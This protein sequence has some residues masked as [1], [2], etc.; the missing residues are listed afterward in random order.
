MPRWIA[1]RVPARA[2]ALAVVATVVALAATLPA[3]RASGL[4][5]AA[6]RHCPAS[7][8]V[9]IEHKGGLCLYARSTPGSRLVLGNT[10]LPL[11]RPIILQG[12][13]WLEAGST[14]GAFLAAE[15]APTLGPVAEPV[16]GGLA[17]V[18]D[19]SL[20]SGG[21][22]AS[23]QRL[24][25]LGRTRVS[26]TIE[27]AG[28]ASAIGFS[29]ENLIG[30]RAVALALPLKI[31]LRSASGL[32][33]RSCYLGSDASPLELLFTD[34]M[35]SPPAPA[36]PIAGKVGMSTQSKS[37]V[38]TITENTLVENAFPLPAVEGCGAKSSWRTE[39]DAA[40]DTRLGLPSPAG[41]NAAILEDTFGA[42]AGT[43][44]KAALGR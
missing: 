21:A 19:P 29:L 11:G 12:G 7:A 22:L 33:G 27:L 9:M 17:A 20:L 24:L 5:L 2:A 30:A 23:Y 28:P 31:R 3:A 40:L 1:D 6:F 25:L 4:N 18:L 16:P 15:G 14:T 43:R 39:I 26:A 8:P 37:E 13:S 35:T 10:I 34:G 32:L 44:V 42:A 36:E 38:V 41:W